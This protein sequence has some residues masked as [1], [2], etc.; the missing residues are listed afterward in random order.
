MQGVRRDDEQRGGGVVSAADREAAL[1]AKA[2]AAAE[3][4]PT[5]SEVL[6]QLDRALRRDDMLGKIEVEVLRLRLALGSYADDPAP[7]LLL[8]EGGRDA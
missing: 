2:D 3:P 8:V 6:D 7:Q 4:L 5:Y 1:L